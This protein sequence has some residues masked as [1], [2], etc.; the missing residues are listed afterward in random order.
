MRR[1]GL[2][3]LAAAAACGGDDGDDDGGGVDLT[4]PVNVVLDGPAPQ[5]LSEW[6]LFAWDAATGTVDWNDTGARMVPYDLNSALFSDFAL[7]QRALYVAPGASA[8]F[9][10]ELAFELPVG[11]VIVKNFAFPADFRAPDADVTLIE[12]RLLVREAAG[13]EPLPYIWDEA[14][15]DAIFTPA[16][17]VRAIDFIDAAGVAQTSSY[18]VP[19]RNQCETCHARKPS[20]QAEPFI[21]PIGSKA[22]HLHRE[23]QLERRTELGVLSGA[24]PVGDIRAAYDFRPVETGGVAAIPPAELDTATRDYLDINCA[25]CHAPDGVQG[26]T[27]QLFLNHTNTDQFRLGV[28][29]RPGSAGAGTGGFEFD[30]VP[31]SPDT[32]ILYFRVQTELVGAMMPLIGRSLVHGRG[33][34]LIH[35]W[36]AAMP[37]DDCI[38]N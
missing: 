16:G 24:P 20:A 32:S 17:E 35:A 2:A 38:A 14:Q 29:K 22:R 28:C 27:S 26:I 8:T 9:D 23:G 30:I 36:I 31:G 34:E 11:S 19:Q 12:T 13:W 3:L 37:A 10:P 7:K 21:V 15:G 1:V 18:L 5:R 6:N 25:H 33:A 4:L